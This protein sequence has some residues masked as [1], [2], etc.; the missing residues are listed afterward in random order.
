VEGFNLI[1]SVMTEQK[2]NSAEVEAQLAARLLTDDSMVLAELL[3][4]FG[5][6]AA[7]AL[8]RRFGGLLSD[9]DLEEALSDAL[10]HVWQARA[11]FDPTKAKLS[12]WFYILARNAAVSSLRR[13]PQGINRNVEDSAMAFVKQE[14]PAEQ[15]A[16][17][18][19]LLT[20]LKVALKSLTPRERIVIEAY[21]GSGGEGNWAAEIAEEVGV[22]PRHIRVIRLRAFD[23]VK[24]RLIAQGYTPPL[25]AGDSHGREDEAH[26]I[27]KCAA[28]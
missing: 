6:Q 19:R 15:S 21:I 12:T 11:R 2:P 28:D 25:A 18:S 24:K 7:S 9:A 16:E 26:G 5:P 27:D 22:P 20:E 14:S 3:R 8:R 10:F 17:R 4:S 13:R 1:G 23:K